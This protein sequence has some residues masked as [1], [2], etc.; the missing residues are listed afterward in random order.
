MAKSERRSLTPE[1]EGDLLQKCL[2][3]CCLCYAL[4]GDDSPK[5]GQI[6]HLDHS[7]SNGNPENFVFLCLRHH[8]MYDA[9][10]GQAKNLTEHEVRRH[11]QTLYDAVAQGRIPAKGGETVL[12]YAPPQS[13]VNVSGDSNVVAGGNVNYTIN[14][15]KATRGK[16][17]SSSRPPIIPGTVSEDARMVGYLNYLVRRYEQFKKWDCDSTGKKMGWGMIRNAYKREMKYELIHTPTEHFERGARYLQGR[18]AKTRLGRM[19]KGKRL[20]SQFNDFDET[21]ADKDP[22]PALE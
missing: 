8:N 16:G 2:R 11:R 5:E 20:Y 6:A 9:T 22:L 4:E 12:R 17:R 21:V 7:R 19:F 3:R 10:M 13:F 14:F 1:N 15:Q 18:I